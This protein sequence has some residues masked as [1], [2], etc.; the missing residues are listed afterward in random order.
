[1]FWHALRLE[2]RCRLRR[3][4]LV[5]VAGIALSLTVGY[6]AT[7]ADESA[8]DTRAPGRF[9]LL[10][11]LAAAVS[12]W[13]A[14]LWFTSNPSHKSSR[15]GAGSDDMVINASLCQTCGFN[16]SGHRPPPAQCPECGS[17]PT[18]DTWRQRAA[19]RLALVPGV[20]ACLS[21]VA[22]SLL[23]LLYFFLS[24]T[25]WFHE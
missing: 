6:L 18:L 14:W 15:M 4:V 21:A 12:F 2:F 9:V 17:A 19:H 13:A 11:L 20:I 3:R 25:E 22:L 7:L 8:W 1:M 24:T 5:T 10:P 16:L 23:A